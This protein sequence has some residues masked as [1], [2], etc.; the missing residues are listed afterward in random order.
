MRST[1]KELY[2]STNYQK[3]EYCLLLKLEVSLQ[4]YEKCISK[5]ETLKWFTETIN[6]SSVFIT[7]CE[8]IHEY[9]H[10]KSCKKLLF[11]LL[12]NYLG[13]REI[14][15]F[16]SVFPL[17]GSTKIYKVNLRIQ[18]LSMQCDFYL[19]PYWKFLN[20]FWEFYSKLAMKALE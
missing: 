11:A 13:L 17:F 19:M 1:E 7:E 3:I 8:Q 14:E 2:W 5:P 6:S 9:Y 4:R 16:W 15:F 10:V 12:I 20:T 18:I